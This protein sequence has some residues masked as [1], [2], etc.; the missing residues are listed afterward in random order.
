MNEVNWQPVSAL[1]GED[2]TVG[3]EF[4]PVPGVPAVS[5]PL[6]LAVDEWV[7]GGCYAPMISVAPPSVAIDHAPGCPAVAAILKAVRDAG[8]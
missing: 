8:Y 2:V 1:T 3:G 6:A 7:C 5:Q 4:E